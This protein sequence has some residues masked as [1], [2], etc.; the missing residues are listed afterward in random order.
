MKITLTDESTGQEIVPLDCE[1]RENQD[2]KTV[3]V[4]KNQDLVSSI[5]EDLKENKKIKISHSNELLLFEY[6]NKKYCTDDFYTVIENVKKNNQKTF[7][8]TFR[9]N[10]G[11]ILKEFLSYKI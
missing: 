8:I 4:I 9:D 7:Y 2:K 5:L 11:K 10:E 1:I 6:N 3:L